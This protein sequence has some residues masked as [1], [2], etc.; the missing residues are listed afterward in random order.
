MTVSKQTTAHKNRQPRIWLVISN[1]LGDNSQVEIIAQQLGL[2]SEIRRVIPKD[3]YVQGKP[4]FKASLYLLDLKQ[5][6]P[7]EPPWP[8]IIITVGRRP[9]MA[10]LWI[11]EQAQGQ[12]KVILV[13]RPRRWIERY[14]LLIIPPQYRVPPLANVYRLQFPAMRPDLQRISKDAEVWRPRLSA[15]KKPLLAVLIGGPTQPMRFDSPVTQ[16]LIEQAS[17]MAANGTLLITTSRRTPDS[18]VS[19]LQKNLLVSKLSSNTY[20]HLHIVAFY[21]KCS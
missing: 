1:K 4:W 17:T 21:D 15:L 3:K 5:S 20:Y 18:V 11:K 8:D 2:P 9:S 19:E 7:L 10:A 14:D 16:K 12:P 13:G 6:D